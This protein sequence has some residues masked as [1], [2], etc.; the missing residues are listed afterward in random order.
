M[1][2]IKIPPQDFPLKMQGGLTREGGRICGTRRYIILG[3]LCCTI[4][5]LKPLSCHSQFCEKTCFQHFM[6]K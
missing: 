2:R 6:P 3:T 5:A 1:R 4:L